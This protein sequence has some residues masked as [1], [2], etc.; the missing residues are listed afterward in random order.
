M[1]KDGFKVDLSKVLLKND[2]MAPWEIWISESQ[3]RMTL[4]VPKENLPAFRQIMKIRDVEVSV[5]GEFN[6]SGK[7]IVECPA[8]IVNNGYGN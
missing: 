8:G 1:G 6:N 5:I 2:D 7:A 4:A 3:E